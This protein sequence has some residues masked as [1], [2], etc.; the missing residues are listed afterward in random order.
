MIRKH[1]T[2]VHINQGMRL[3]KKSVQK[4]LQRELAM[5]QKMKEK[6]EGKWRLL[7]IGELYFGD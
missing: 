1:K 6:K 4:Q 3:S 5:E 7:K 2:A